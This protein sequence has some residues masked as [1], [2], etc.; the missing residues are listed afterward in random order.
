MHTKMEIEKIIEP[1]LR[2]HAVRKAALF[3]SYADGSATEESD[4]DVLVEFCGSK[5]LLDLIE[6]ND[7]LESPLKNK[8]DVVTYNSLHP[9]LRNSILAEQK[10]IYEECS[11]TGFIDV[12]SVLQPSFSSELYRRS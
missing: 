6:L 3:G 12:H 9:L 1:I 11:H 8:V 2:K 10:M 5:S 7:A 4:V